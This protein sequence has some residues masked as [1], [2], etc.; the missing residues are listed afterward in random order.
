MAD[1]I[2]SLVL[3]MS[4]DIRKLEKGLSQARG[5][6]NRQ[7][8]T[9]EGRFDKMNKNVLR[10]TGSM[11]KNLTASLVAIG[12]ALGLRETVQF[13]DAWTQ[14]A[15]KLSA[16]GVAADKLGE[17]QER[18]VKLSLET[19]TG[20]TE[21]VDL[22]SR[23][24]RSTQQLGVSQADVFQ[25]TKTLNQAFKAGGASIEEQRAAIT[26]LSQALSSGALQGDELRSIRENAPLVAKAIANEFGVTMGELK[27][28]GAEGK[29][30]TDRIFS[31]I[32]KAGQEIE[33][34]FRSTQSTIAD[35]FV[36]LG[37][38]ATAFVGRLN[39]AYGVSALIA[40]VLNNAAKI[41]GAGG[42]G[43][44]Q[45]KTVQAL[46]V[47]GARD[48]ADVTRVLA[49]IDATIELGDVTK[50]LS[51]KETELAAKRKQEALDRLTG[52]SAELRL[53][54]D[55]TNALIKAEQLNA[56]SAR[57]IV[58]PPNVKSAREESIVAMQNGL[59]A[60]AKTRSALTDRI[61]A[62]IRADPS[63]FLKDAD[64]IGH[65]ED[66]EKSK[67]HQFTTDLDDFAAALKEIQ[68]SEEGAAA[69]SRAAVQA[70]LDYAK[71]T[72]DVAAATLLMSDLPGIFVPADWNLLHKELA[73]V[74][75]ESD[76]IDFDKATAG[77][78]DL[79]DL[80]ASLGP[81]L[82]DNAVD[83]DLQRSGVFPTAEQ[84]ALRDRMREAVKEGLRQGIETDDWGQ[85]LRN[86][87]AESIT[88][89]L[90]KSL[91]ALADM[92]T[93][94]LFGDSGRGGVLGDLASAVFGGFSK[95]P[96]R[97]SGGAT[98]PFTR[99]QVNE[100]GKGEFLFMGKNPGQVLTA[101][102]INGLSAGG[103]GGGA[104]TINAPLIVQGSIDSATL[105]QVRT[106]MAENN[107]RIAASLPGAVNATMLDNRKHKRRV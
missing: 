56:K 65:M 87:L 76:A 23:L 26:Q 21:T 79:K 102:Q 18:L 10:S 19:R 34:Q 59:E 30:T 2:E 24:T 8:T 42:D 40:D 50:N 80:V 39:D 103:R 107:R 54:R 7:L 13:A 105:P 92:L 49:E 77:L 70:V 90:D 6:T 73:K 9:I 16:A 78:M 33:T 14:A 99:H 95:G 4:A 46:R 25:V 1:R 91:N 11:A 93:Q 88:A 45:P 32:L 94:F 57:V 29:L 66:D 17:T 22:Y 27:K 43:D 64:L 48:Q 5:T 41:V 15:N 52:L 82:D 83:R 31:G 61:A 98:F 60:I 36:N 71:A 72:K 97:A 28:L 44:V 100:T 53:L 69:K 81:G 58:E 12:A 38:A 89:A 106:M 20:L 86:I 68:K 67:L 74:K 75:E 85:S 47:R 37:T 96:G 101:S 55:Y 3:Q 62:V 84:Q 63:L 104:T 35:A 51:E